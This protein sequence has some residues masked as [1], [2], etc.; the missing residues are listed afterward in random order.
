MRYGM[1]VAMVPMMVP[2][3][4]GGYLPVLPPAISLV[5]AGFSSFVMVSTG[6]ST[7]DHVISAAADEDCSMLRVVFGEEPCRAYDGDTEKP[8]TELVAY[9][10]GDRDD[11]VDGVNPG[12]YCIG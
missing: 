8:L 7:A 10:P 12:W 2:I 5:S 4:L 9:Y 3:L 6:K 11:W 1:A